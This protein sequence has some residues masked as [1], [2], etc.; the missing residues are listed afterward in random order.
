M[1]AIIDERAFEFCGEFLRKADLI[2]WGL[3]QSRMDDAKVE[4]RALRDHTG[5]YSDL[6]S[7]IY[8]KYDDETETIALY[9]YEHGQTSIPAGEGWESKTN[10]YSN[11]EDSS[12]NATGLHDTRIEGLY[13]HGNTVEYYMYWPIFSNQI[14]NSQQYLVNDYYY[15][16]M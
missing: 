1:D 10:Y 16:K 14:T 5:K 9:G 6:G 15:A 2:R 4:L 8:Y 11:T 12:G 13:K 7:T 3:L